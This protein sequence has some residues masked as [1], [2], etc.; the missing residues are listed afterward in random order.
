MSQGT[1]IF[2]WYGHMLEKKIRTSGE[3]QTVIIFFLAKT[4]VDQ[5]KARKKDHK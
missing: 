3:T 4:L 2:I 5:E 1:H